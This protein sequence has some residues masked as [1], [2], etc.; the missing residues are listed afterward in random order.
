VRVRRV[1]GRGINVKPVAE[2]K[3]MKGGMVD[4]SVNKF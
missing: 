4:L 1:T 3:T 2:K